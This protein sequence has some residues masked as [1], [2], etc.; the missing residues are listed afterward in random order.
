MAGLGKTKEDSLVR[1]IQWF[2]TK[3]YHVLKSMTLDRGHVDFSVPGISGLKQCPF[4][5]LV[6]LSLF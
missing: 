6:E 2:G 4:M 5:S 3:M 1:R